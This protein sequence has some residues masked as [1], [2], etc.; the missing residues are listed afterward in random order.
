MSELSTEALARLL[1][2]LRFGHLERRECSAAAPMPEADKDR[3]MWGHPDAS[4]TDR[5]LAGNELIVYH[6][7]HCGLNFTAFP[8]R[9]CVSSP[10]KN[11]PG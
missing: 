7:P 2:Q 4:E 3:F 9:S 8:P 1:H 5:F 10:T 6:C 11:G